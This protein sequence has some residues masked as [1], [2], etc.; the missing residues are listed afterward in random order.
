MESSRKYIFKYWFIWELICNKESIKN[1]KIN[2]KTAFHLL[3]SS[4]YDNDLYFFRKIIFNATK[5]DFKTFSFNSITNIEYKKYLESIFDENTIHELYEESDYSINASMKS[6]G[7][8]CVGYISCNHI[9]GRT[10]NTL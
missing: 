2:L 9:F 8:I 7:N 5:N 4:I 3:N 6:A 1:K 10:D